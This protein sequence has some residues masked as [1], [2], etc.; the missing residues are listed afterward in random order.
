ML[1]ETDLI[2]L[3]Y[4]PDLTEGGI[5]YACRSLAYTYNRMGGTMFSRLRRIVVGVAVELAL[6]RYLYGQNVPFD[7]L[8]ATPFT[9][10]DR[11]D[12]ALGRHHCDVKSYLISRR[13]QIS[14]LRRQPQSALQAQA[15]IPVEQFMAE[16]H[17]AD[18]LYLFAFLLGL[19][20]TSRQEM[21]RARAAGQPL[22]L[23]HP[24]PEPWSRPNCWR[25]LDRLTLKSE[26]EETLLV[27]LGGQDANREFV[28][29]QC[30]LPSR[31]RV[32]AACEFYTLC[33][34]HVTAMP[35]ARVGVYSPVCGAPYLIPP[36]AW[37]NIWIYGMEIW[38]L[39]WLTH[40]EFRRRAITLVPGAAAFPYDR[41]RTKNLAVP[42]AEL[43]PL[44]PLLDR[45]REWSQ[46]A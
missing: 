4:T 5:A 25:P 22:Y 35:S 13:H 10:P 14:R 43:Q 18:D 11:Y 7:V 23:V 36:A 6:R 31:R 44:S 15:L 33:Y 26:C 29:W 27:E 34:L 28:I 30:E 42:M 9:E 24:L 19:V 46:V 41:T 2:R 8:G 12:I 38:L 17:R 32:V 40:E 20:A 37:G 1:H 39:G 3:P 16:G 21:G 45:V